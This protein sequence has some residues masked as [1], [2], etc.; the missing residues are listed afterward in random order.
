MKLG[1]FGLLAVALALTGA[2]F[3]QSFG[4]QSGTPS[5]DGKVI[6][7]LKIRSADPALIMLLLSGSQST[8]T[9]PEIS[10][11][12]NTGNAG[13]G[14]AGNRNGFGGSNSNGNGF[15]GNN[16]GNFPGNFPGSDQGRG[17]R[18]GGGGS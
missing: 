3:A 10:T 13:F 18:R 4:G 8:S 15:A 6:R 7:R 1:K 11:V 9:P 16:R 2:A 5:E 12:I 17:S 14:G